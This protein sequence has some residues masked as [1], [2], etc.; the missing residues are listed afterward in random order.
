VAIATRSVAAQASDDK[1]GALFEVAQFNRCVSE[2]A[3]S[4]LEPEVKEPLFRAYVFMKRTNSLLNAAFAFPPSTNGWA[5]AQNAA[6]AEIKEATPNIKPVLDKIRNFLSRE[7][8]G[9]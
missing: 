7:P 9:E 1:L 2:G 8:K 4:L 5:E 3:N 6:R